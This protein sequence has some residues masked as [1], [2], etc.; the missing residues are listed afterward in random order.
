MT[1]D[2]VDPV[3][4]KKGEML[5]NAIVHTIHNL[6]KK[7]AQSFSN[8]SHLAMDLPRVLPDEK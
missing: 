7:R 2:G 1:L 8:H 3:I 6:S 4:I 5:Q